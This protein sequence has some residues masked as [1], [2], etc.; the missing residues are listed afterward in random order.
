MSHLSFGELY[1]R[2]S[3][4]QRGTLM[5]NIMVVLFLVI[6]VS[7]IASCGTT[8]TGQTSQTTPIPSPTLAPTPTAQAT[9]VRPG[10]QPSRSQLN[11]RL[12]H[13]RPYLTCG[14]CR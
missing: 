9:R 4:S 3:Q 1:N 5:K 7:I 8:A 6:V 14:R 2:F 10:R 13:N 12:L 11:P